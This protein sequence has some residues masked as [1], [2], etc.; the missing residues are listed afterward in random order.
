MT[1]TSLKKIDSEN[2]HFLLRKNVLIR[3]HT[4]VTDIHVSIVVKGN[5]LFL[6]EKVVN[7]VHKVNLMLNKSSHV[8]NYIMSLNS[9]QWLKLTWKDIQIILWIIIE[10]IKLISKLKTLIN[11]VLMI[12]HMVLI[13]DVNNAK[14]QL[15]ISIWKKEFV[16]M[17]KNLSISTKLEKITC[18][19]IQKL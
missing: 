2:N 17:L 1:V 8:N 6:K 12:H 15:H 11:N 13:M 16:P 9:H 7:H 3:L 19:Q 14:I 10:K 5:I 4:L 18:L